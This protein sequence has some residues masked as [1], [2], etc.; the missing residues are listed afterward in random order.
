MNEWAGLARMGSFLSCGLHGI[1]STPQI[2]IHEIVDPDG[3]IAE[4]LSNT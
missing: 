3:D 2:T 1:L 4:Q